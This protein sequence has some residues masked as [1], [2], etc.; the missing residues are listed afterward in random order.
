MIRE[1]KVEQDYLCD[2]LE[3]GAYRKRWQKRVVFSISGNDARTRIALGGT[4]QERDKD[5]LSVYLLL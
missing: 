3:I 1:A 2:L 5:L 4:E